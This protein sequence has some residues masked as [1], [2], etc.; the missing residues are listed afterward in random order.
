[1]HLFSGLHFESFKDGPERRK[2]KTDTY[3]LYSQSKAA[4]VVVAKEF[5][6]KYAEQGIISI[7]L[8]P[9][10]LFYSIY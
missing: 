2:W 1:M 10:L 9:G 7:S 4:N 3:G 8:N 5:A 6:R